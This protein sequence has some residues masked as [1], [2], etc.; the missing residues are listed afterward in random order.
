MLQWNCVNDKA[1]QKLLLFNNSTKTFNWLFNLLQ[2]TKY[3]NDFVEKGIISVWILVNIADNKWAP[4]SKIKKKFYDRFSHLVNK[5]N[6]L[7]KYRYWN[8]HKSFHTLSDAC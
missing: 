1:K 5:S 4:N 7:V 8:I 3:I 2:Y 6:S